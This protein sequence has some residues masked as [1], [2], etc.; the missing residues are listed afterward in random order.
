MPRF[1]IQDRGE[2]PGEQA[3]VVL[4]QCLDL[5]VKGR[6]VF[7]A[8]IVGEGF[9]AE[10]FEHCRPFFGSA[11]CAS[12][13][14]MHHAS[15]CRA[16]TNCRV[17]KARRPAAERNL[18]PMQRRLKTTPREDRHVHSNDL[19]HAAARPVVPE[20]VAPEESSTK[21]WHASGAVSL[22]MLNL[23]T[24]LSHSQSISICSWS[25]R[26][27]RRR[28]NVAE[29]AWNVPSFN[30]RRYNFVRLSPAFSL[31]RPQCAGACSSSSAC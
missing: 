26:T 9:E 10:P 8:I 20:P 15:N 22:R 29:G 30:R 31:S 6:N 24:S 17:R 11:F 2:P 7:L 13:G 5:G 25:R 18:R 27:S 3:N 4:V 12:N 16:R 19:D 21:S 14:T 1:V 28:G 23:G